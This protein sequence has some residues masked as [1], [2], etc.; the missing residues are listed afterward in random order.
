LDEIITGNQGVITIN[1]RDSII[2]VVNNHCL[3]ILKKEEAKLE[4]LESQ[5]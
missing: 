2:D 3:W 4:L 5:G 1:I